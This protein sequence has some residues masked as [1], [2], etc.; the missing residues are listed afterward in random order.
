MYSVIYGES[1]VITPKDIYESVALI[2]TYS[3]PHKP[4]TYSVY[5]RNLK[6][7]RKYISDY[8]G[9]TL[10]EHRIEGGSEWIKV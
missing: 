1:N 9:G 8:L 5:T 6:H 4:G 7:W 2:N 10:N 3:N